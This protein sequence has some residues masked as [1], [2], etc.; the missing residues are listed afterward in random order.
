MLRAVRLAAKLGL[1]LDGRDARR[2]AAAPLME[3]VPPARCST[4]C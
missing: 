1:T 4:R 3:R 2:S